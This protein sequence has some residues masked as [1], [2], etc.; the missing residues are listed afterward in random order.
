MIA[1]LRIVNRKH[2][3]IWLPR[4]IQLAPVP[5]LVVLVIIHGMNYHIA[6]NTLQEQQSKVQDVANLIGPDDK[7]YVHGTLEILV[8]LNK[9]NMN[10]YIFFDR[11]KDR[12]IANR[13]SG[14]FAAIMDEMKAQAPKIIAI[15]RIQN[16]AYRQELLSWAA[17]DYD[18]FPIEFA[19]NSVYVRKPEQ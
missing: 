10:P 11:G 6:D 4:G 16:V 1:K 9:P 5:I 8:L 15:S 14:G 18:R 17:Q 12:Y 7:I 13:T 2:I 19:H 3:R